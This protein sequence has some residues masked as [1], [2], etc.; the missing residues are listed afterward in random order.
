MDA[1]ALST[2]R[3][4]D[5]SIAHAWH[6]AKF[7]ALA[8]AGK[9]RALSNYISKKSMGKKSAAAEAVAFFHAM[10]AAG[11]PVTITRVERKPPVSPR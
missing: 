1:A 10:K 8:Q 2:E 3:E 7:N 5:L 9:L 4:Y 11:L 6:A